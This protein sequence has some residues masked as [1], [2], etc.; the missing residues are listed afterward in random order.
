MS[1]VSYR[2]TEERPRVRENLVAVKSRDY[3]TTSFTNVFETLTL[4]KA[5]LLYRI[6]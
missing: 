6:I 1:L 4:D 5:T 3:Q 2:E